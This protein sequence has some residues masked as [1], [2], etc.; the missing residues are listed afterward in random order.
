MGGE[1]KM[2]IQLNYISDIKEFSEGCRFYDSLIWLKQD[3]QVINGKSIMGIFALDLNRPVE[4]EIETENK[5]V[6]DDFYSFVEKWE[7][8]NEEA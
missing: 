6:M 3:G 2:W 7:V 8:K 1:L 4:I 5:N